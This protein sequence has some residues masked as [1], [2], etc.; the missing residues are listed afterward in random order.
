MAGTV[1]PDPVRNHVVGCIAHDLVFCDQALAGTC[2][3]GV[4][5]IPRPPASGVQLLALNATIEA[6]RAGDAGTGFA[7]VAGEVEELARETAQATEDVSSRVATI[8]GDVQ[9]VVGALTSI[10]RSSA[11]S[12]RPSST[13]ARCSPSRPASRAASSSWAEPSGG[14]REQVRQDGRTVPRAH[15][16]AP[17]SVPRPPART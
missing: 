14:S 5:R 1:V 10:G 8:Q 3:G 11:G 12:T 7:V 4:G 6:A 13:S 15:V 2:R 17:V 9:D 16:E